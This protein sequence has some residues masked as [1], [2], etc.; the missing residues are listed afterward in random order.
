RFGSNDEYRR[1]ADEAHQHG[2]KIVMDM[3][4]NHCG[5]DHPWVFDIPSKDWFNTAEWLENNSEGKHNEK[6][7][8]TSYKLTPVMDPY[9]SEIDMKETVDGWF[10]KL[11]SPMM[12]K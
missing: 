10:L 7:L 4:F 8:Q 9:A 11:M 12:C 2:L 6:Y 5:F 3:I 1:L